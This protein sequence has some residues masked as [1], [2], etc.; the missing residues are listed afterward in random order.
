MNILIP[1]AGEG[2][3]FRDAGFKMPKPLVPVC[4]EPMIKRVIDNLGG[5]ESHF[6][7]VVQMRHIH[8]FGIDK[9]LRELAPGCNVIAVDGL[10]GGAAVTALRASAFIDNYQPLLIANADQL[11]HGWSLP[12][13]KVD[14]V[15]YTFYSKQMK[16]SYCAVGNYGRVW[17]VAEKQVISSYATCGIY[18]WRRGSDF[19]KYAKQMVDEGRRC[20]G[21]F[22]IAPVYNEAIE[23]GLEIRVENVD[24]MH[25]LGTPEDLKVYEDFECPRS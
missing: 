1:M 10:T 7:F 13:D 4:G 24:A 14:G 25:G 3:R 23:A 19:V 15:I 2:S 12:D 11:V 6:I 8:E 18:Y 9:T 21:E 16:W 5:P 22:Y 20:N 17:G